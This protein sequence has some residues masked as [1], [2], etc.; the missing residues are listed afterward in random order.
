MRR[1]LGF[2]MLAAVLTFSVGIGLAYAFDHAR[3]EPASAVAI[4]GQDVA[5]IPCP[6]CMRLGTVMLRPCD[7][8]YVVKCR[9]CGALGPP[10]DSPAEAAENWNLRIYRP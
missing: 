7:E 3:P 8:R 6:Y 9:G 10:G 4:E 5:L 1:S 2:W